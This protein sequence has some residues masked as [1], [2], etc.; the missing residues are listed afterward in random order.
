[1]KAGVE[2]WSCISLR[3]LDGSGIWVHLIVIFV[4]ID[5][6]FSQSVE[7]MMTFWSTLQPN[8]T[9]VARL[10]E[11]GGSL[12]QVSKEDPA[13]LRPQTALECGPLR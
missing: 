5:L 3:R 8:P 6:E 1:M 13:S 10:S 11:R 2:S 12:R 4:F 9:F 7:M